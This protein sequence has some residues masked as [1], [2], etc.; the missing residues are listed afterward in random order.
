MR[1]P[2]ALGLT[3]VVLTLGT[4]QAQTGGALP[5]PQS[6]QQVTPQAVPPGTL[7]STAEVIQAIDTATQELMVASDLLRSKEV[8]NALRRAA[9]DRSVTVFVVAPP[10]NVT[11]PSS[12]FVSL[13]FA[14]VAVRLVPFEG[15]FIVIDRTVLI[16]GP[17][18][19]GV[20][21][22]PGVQVAPTR[23]SQDAAE[24]SSF[25]ESFYQ[26]FSAA[27]PYSTET[28]L[29]ALDLEAEEQP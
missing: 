25:V 2:C 28:F 1:R 23:L 12:Y 8:A 9:V 18:I 13:A 4:S 6:A 5:P 27:E 14:D 7:Q 10:E 21:Q 11:D 20:K 29:E 15:S 26:S 22:L 16:E 24:V 17:L 3:L 19:A